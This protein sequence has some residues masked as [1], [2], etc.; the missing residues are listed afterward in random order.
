MR[1][2][3]VM[4]ARTRWEGVRV[5]GEKLLGEKLHLTVETYEWWLEQVKAAGF[6]VKYAFITPM[7]LDV[8]AI[9]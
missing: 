9:K 1:I 5:D 6:K 3:L 8:F 7:V 2:D 4:I